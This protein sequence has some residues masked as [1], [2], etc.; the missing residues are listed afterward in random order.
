MKRSISSQ[1]FKSMP[2]HQHTMQPMRRVV[3]AN[4][5]ASDV[6]QVASVTGAQLDDMP[7]IV[8]AMTSMYDVHD[9][10]QRKS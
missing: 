2:A 9:M 8:A 6:Y 4:C 10:Y 3:S 1:D 7:C 5:L